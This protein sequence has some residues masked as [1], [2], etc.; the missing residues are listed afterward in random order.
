[1]PMPEAY[2]IK[3]KENPYIGKEDNFQKT[4]AR[5]MWL[6]YPEVLWFHCPN[7][8]SRNVLEG[9]KFKA[10]GVLPGVSDVLILEPKKG[11]N[12]LIIELKVSKGKLQKTQEHFLNKATLRGYKCAVCYNMDSAIST[13]K[14]YFNEN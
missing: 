14:K 3:G 10:M 8:G 4:F 2:E 9:A 1:M 6:A 11:F 12:G 7:G 5:F 13:I